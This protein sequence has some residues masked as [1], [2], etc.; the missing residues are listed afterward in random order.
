M[1]TRVAAMVLRVCAL[2][3]IVL[4]ILFW[5][6]NATSWREIHMTA[7]IVLVLS[8]W[9]I[10]ITRVRAPGGA[11][12]LLSALVVGIALAV[13]GVTQERILLNSQHWIVQVAHLTLALLAVG[14]GEMLAGRAASQP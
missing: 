3:A 10:A 9:T 2:I 8:L 4:G 1:V 11:W 6:G 14:I 12:R 13:I 7:G 5:T